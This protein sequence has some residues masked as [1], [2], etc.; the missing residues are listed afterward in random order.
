MHFSIINTFWVSIHNYLQIFLNVSDFSTFQQ[1]NLH[2]EMEQPI[3][4]LTFS[5]GRLGKE[6]HGID[7]TLGISIF[8]KLIFL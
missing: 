2:I 3:G 5:S 1:V 7:T 8:Q 6:S 4:T